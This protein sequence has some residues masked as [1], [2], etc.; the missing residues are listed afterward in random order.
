MRMRNLVLIALLSV[1]C[2]DAFPEMPN[3]K[4]HYFSQ[5]DGLSNTFACCWAQDSIGFVWVG[6]VNGLNRYD[7][8]HFKSYMANRDDTTMLPHQHISHLYVMPNGKL[9]V[10][11]KRGIVT[12]DRAHDHFEKVN[13]EN[14]NVKVNFDVSHVDMDKEGN[15]F[16]SRGSELYKYHPEDNYLRLYAT[17]PEG[18][19]SRFIFDDQ[20]G[21]WIG[22]TNGAKLLWFNHQMTSRRVLALNPGIANDYS[23]VNGMLWHNS[24]LIVG[25]LKGG[26]YAVSPNTFATDPLPVGLPDADNALFLNKDRHGNIWSIDYTGLKLFDLNKKA[27]EAVYP[28]FSNPTSIKDGISGIFQDN[29]NNYW[30][31]YSNGGIGIHST[32]KGFNRIADDTNDYWRLNHNKVISMT[33]DSHYNLWF[34]VDPPQLT[35]F[36][37]AKGQTEHLTGI[38]EWNRLNL[39]GGTVRQL[40]TDLDGILWVATYNGGLQ[41]FNE[42][43]N[44]F[45]GYMH[46]DDD[47]NSIMGN[48]II[49]LANDKEG[50][51]WLALHGKGVDKF[52]PITQKFAHF[53]HEDNNLSNPWTNDIICDKKGRVWVTSGWGLSMLPKGSDKFVTFLARPNDSTSLSS[54]NTLSVYEDAEGYI[55]IGTDQGLNR[56]NEEN[57]NFL[58][59]SDKLDD[60]NI[61]SILDDNFGYLWV[62]TLGG[63]SR[64]DKKTFEVVN[65]EESDGIQADEFIVNSSYKSWEGWL[66]FGG[67]NGV[68]Y[69]D[70]GKIKFN[71]FTPPV[72]INSIEVDGS[73]VT[74]F[75]KQITNIDK[76]YSN[77]GIL[78]LTHNDKVIS[79]NYAGLGFNNTSRQK[80]K[81]KL[82]GFDNDWRY[83]GHITQITYNYLPPNDYTFKVIAANNDGVWN[84]IETQLR[85]HISPPWYATILFKILVLAA[86]AA[87]IYVFLL[88]RTR[89]LRLQHHSLSILVHNKTEEL[90]STNQELMAQTEYLDAVNK[91]LKEKQ[92]KVESQAKILAV[93]TEALRKSNRDLKQ[94]NSTKDRLFSIIA[95][96]LLNPFTS[97]MGLSEL[98]NED[99]AS[100][101]EPE[102][103][104]LTTTIHTSSSRL[105]NLL[106]NLLLWARSQTSAIKFDPQTFPI[107]DILEEATE[108]FHDQIKVKQLNFSIVCDPVLCVY[109]DVDMAKTIF[110]NLVNN[111]IKFTPRNGTIGIMV[112]ETDGFAE[113]SVVDTGVGMKEE[114][115]KLLFDPSCVKTTT[116]TD[117]EAGTGLG[118]IICK[119]FI[120][121]NKGSITVNSI[122][123]AGTTFVVRLPMSAW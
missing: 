46:H 51:L 10:F 26:N 108:H 115:A 103:L 91:E 37:Y 82:E 50:N 120:E 23:P 73:A 90:Q 98:L 93:Q 9:W 29:Q 85:I 57:G 105:F 21:L 20:N 121:R 25:M 83:M 24:Q 32:D 104:E 87:T 61:S 71:P 101:T 56:Y 13:I 44:R 58:R 60:N 64:I 48:D 35:V 47:G 99:Y 97:I 54:S 94:L 19:I 111:A 22:L 95:H 16:V 49:G 110:R 1:W 17:L 96:D 30:T 40:F 5:K 11:T 4:F 84:P 68:T 52:D 38:N 77:G 117:G 6:T 53:T 119:E 43:T 80:Y 12:Y 62:S 106:Q 27:Y 81:V 8:Q 2:F 65:F 42:K 14:C 102:R 116:G 122:L 36:R 59:L 67:I 76:D 33:K 86:F 18:T 123:G 28:N 15:L 3:W 70:P 89:K 72:V 118:L 7:G 92:D 63:I 112:A 39:K 113:I 88:M 100:M 107:N 69:F 66:Y 78:E 31:I 41:Y 79:I 109:T 55:W 75:R 45:V 114:T 34:G 74:D